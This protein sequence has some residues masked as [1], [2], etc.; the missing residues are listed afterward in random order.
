[1]ALV[2]CSLL[3]NLS[4]YKCIYIHICPTPYIYI[5]I[6]IYQNIRHSLWYKNC[7]ADFLYIQTELSWDAL[8]SQQLRCLGAEI[9]TKLSYQWRV[10]GIS[11]HSFCLSLFSPFLPSMGWL[12]GVEVFGLIVFS[13]SPRLALPTPWYCGLIFNN[14]NDYYNNNNT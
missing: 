3:R 7:L 12:C 13:I 4:R 14:K 1:M 11:A 9:Q 6:H 2:I 10:A 8:A 5:Y